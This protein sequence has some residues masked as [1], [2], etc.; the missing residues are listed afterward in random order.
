MSPYFSELSSSYAYEIED[1]TW[2]SG[3]DNVLATRLKAKRSQFADLLPMCAFDPVMVAPAFRGAFRFDE[4]EV[5]DRL[6]SS[7]PGAFPTWEELAAAM[8]LEPWAAKLA[9]SALAID[10]GEEFM[11]VAAGLEYVMSGHA[12]PT[13]AAEPEASAE[14]G[15]G[16]AGDG[17]EDADLAEAGEDYLSEQGF[18]RRS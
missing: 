5:F 12:L 7:A 18:D 1:L 4:R 10:G 15:E 8:E 9:R 16:D 14:E 11:Q 6:V 17:D 13:A 3:G 2:D